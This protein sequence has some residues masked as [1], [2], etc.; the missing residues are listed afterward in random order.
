MVIRVSNIN[1]AFPL[2]TGSKNT[3]VLHIR[4]KEATSFV[5]GDGFALSWPAEG[6]RAC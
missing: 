1:S 4:T 6:H 3:V 2:S 5:P